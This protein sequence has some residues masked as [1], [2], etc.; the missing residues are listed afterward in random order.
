MN[1]FK[2]ASQ[3]FNYLIR[4]EQNFLFHLIVGMIVLIMG[5]ILNLSLV[6]MSI[7][8]C[9][10]GIMLSIEALNT[11]IERVVDLVTEEEHPIAKVAKDVSAAAVFLF[12]IISVIIGFLLFFEP[13]TRLL[14]S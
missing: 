2:Y 1:S 5:L 11:G 3:G 6:K 7:L 14:Q 12:A 10:I 9:V 13:I 8:L 4:N